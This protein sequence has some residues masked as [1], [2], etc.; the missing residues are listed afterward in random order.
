MRLLPSIIL[1]A[2]WTA[3]A[4]AADP[5]A[6]AVAP[7]I[8]D[9]TF[10]IGWVDPARI[11]LDAV[12]TLV[13]SAAKIAGPSPQPGATDEIATAKTMLKAWLDEFK[14][15]GGKDLYLVASLT[16]LP[17]S[18]KPFV[19]VP[20]GPKANAE[21]ISALLFSGRP[22][23]PTSGNEEVPNAYPNMTVAKI[24]AAVVLGSRQTIERLR[25]LKPTPRPEFAAA[26]EAAGDAPA[27]IA[28]APTADNRRVIEDMIPTLPSELGGGPITAVTHGCS[29]ISLGISTQNHVSVK[30][31]V[32]SQDAAAAKTLAAVIDK[33]RQFLSESKEL[34]VLKIDGSRLAGLLKPTVR[35]DRLLLDLAGDTV[36]DAVENLLIPPIA[37]AR[38]QALRTVSAVN[39]RGIMTALYQCGEKHN[40]QWPESLDVLVKENYVQPKSLVNPTR[41]PGKTGYIYVRPSEEL[42]KQPERLV[43]YEAFDKWDEGVYVSFGDAHVEWVAD[44]ARF[45][46][47]L[48]E[49]LEKGTR[50]GPASD[51]SKNGSASSSGGNGSNNS[52][53]G[54]NS[55]R[56]K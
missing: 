9:Q 35:D 20:L 44:E 39:M 32:Q 14:K 34:R 22:D 37:N 43:L 40:K 4:G 51:S 18:D 10:A 8:D 15:A 38:T 23:G 56:S 55:N 28:I 7:F 24:G 16:D 49:A 1:L 41:P 46:K 17:K 45:K 25:T 53:G 48:A 6:A 21:A 13:R 12:E 29:W 52:N 42:G 19:V 27:C 50:T 11:D 30:V 33:G 5:R 36:R 47:L 2:T 26:L 31:V 3:T 54:G